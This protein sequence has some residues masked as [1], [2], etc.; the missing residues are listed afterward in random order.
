MVKS[1]QT[2]DILKFMA[3]LLRVWGVGEPI[4]MLDLIHLHTYV[5]LLSLYLT[6]LLWMKSS[7]HMTPSGILY[8]EFSFPE[9]LLSMEDLQGRLQEIHIQIVIEHQDHQGNK[10]GPSQTILSFSMGVPAWFTNFNWSPECWA[11][12][13]RAHHYCYL[14]SPRNSL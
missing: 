5:L 12:G 3:L 14:S 13:F 10:A 9:L 8:Y 7:Y 6:T 1:N 2:W 11:L 4:L